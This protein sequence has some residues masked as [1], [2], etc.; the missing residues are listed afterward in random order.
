MLE[1]SRIELVSFIKMRIRERVI[2]FCAETTSVFLLGGMREAFFGGQPSRLGSEKNHALWIIAAQEQF[3]S[4]IIM[5]VPHVRLHEGQMSLTRELL[6]RI[7]LWPN[8]VVERQ[9]DS[10]NQIIFDKSVCSWAYGIIRRVPTFF[11][12]ERQVNL[13]YHTIGFVIG[14]QNQYESC[15]LPERLREEWSASIR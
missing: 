6:H 10:V 4:S 8:E 15:S 3:P 9:H 2:S 11:K 14:S 7:F 13:T 5:G 1:S 12:T